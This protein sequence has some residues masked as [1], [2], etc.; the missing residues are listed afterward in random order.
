MLCCEMCN[1]IWKQYSVKSGY[2]TDILKTIFG[3]CPVESQY[4]QL[5]PVETKCERPRHT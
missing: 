5:I 3:L 4:K 1:K 2:K